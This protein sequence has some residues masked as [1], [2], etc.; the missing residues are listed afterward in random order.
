MSFLLATC[1]SEGLLSLLCHAGNFGRN[2]SAC[3]QHEI[4]YAEWGM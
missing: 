4:Q 3:R 1:L 2:W